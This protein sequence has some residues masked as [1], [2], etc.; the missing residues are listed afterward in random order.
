M[1]VAN[2]CLTKR[3]I[4]KSLC[5][6]TCELQSLP[7]AVDLWSFSEGMYG[8]G[9]SMAMVLDIGLLQFHMQEIGEILSNHDTDF[10]FRWSFTVSHVRSF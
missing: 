5:F 7:N 1:S 2:T 8:D 10:L 4:P 6:S 3:R 9:N